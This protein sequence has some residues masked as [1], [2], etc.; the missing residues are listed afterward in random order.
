M[1]I[2]EARTTGRVVSLHLHP[3]VPG[4]P[5]RQV[6]SFELVADLGIQGNERYF[7]RRSRS[8][9]PSPRQVS[10]MEREQIGAHART[11]GLDSLAPGA[12]RAN[13]ETSG[14]ELVRLVG[15][16][17][18]IGEATLLLA[19]ARM[20]CAKMDA[21]CQGLRALMEGHRQGVL[22]RVIKSGRVSEGDA[23]V[24]LGAAQPVSSGPSL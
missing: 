15:Q 12:V 16:S 3:A 20:P 21:L 24:V 17:V 1:D 23:I 22:A 14:M 8:G 6:H 5:M 19:E 11:L 18:Q 10:L 2:R 7:G 13:I 4:A 9:G